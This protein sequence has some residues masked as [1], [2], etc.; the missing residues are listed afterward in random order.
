MHLNYQVVFV[1]SSSHSSKGCVAT[2]VAVFP[3]NSFTVNTSSDLEEIDKITD[4]DTITVNLLWRQWATDPT[5][6]KGKV[7]FDAFAN[8][9]CVN[10]S[11][12]DEVAEARKIFNLI[13]EDDDG[14]V[15]FPD[16]LLFLFCLD[17][18]VFTHI[19]SSAL[20][21]LLTQK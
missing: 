18:K 11:D 10:L 15:E 19:F 4:L 2:F 6:K 3:L 5:T 14:K 8:Q 12:D 21:W 16:V 17:E 13:D 9:L 20:N 7:K 1:G